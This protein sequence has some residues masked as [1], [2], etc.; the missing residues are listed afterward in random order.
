MCGF[1]V[2]GAAE[3]VDAFVRHHHAHRGGLAHNAMLGCEAALLQFGNH[4]RRAEAADF[5]IV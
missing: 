4:H 5:F 2:H 1:A 3:G